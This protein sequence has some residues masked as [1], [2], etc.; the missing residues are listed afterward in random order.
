M[1]FWNT[2]V[3]TWSI[4]WTGFIQGIGAGVILVPVQMVAFSQ[5]HP[6]QRNEGTAVFNLVR[7]MFSSIGVSIT[8]A[9]FVYVG[10]TGRAEMVEHINPYNQALQYSE[11][12]GGYTTGSEHGLAVIGKEIDRQASMLG[13]N[14]SFMML[15]VGS[16]A[17][18]PMVLL[19]GRARKPEG[20]GEELGE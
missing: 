5:L 15:A 17:A 19:I 18:M 9:V 4:V 6:R 3:G 12:S 16:F 1:A 20:E 14:A 11:H 2:N 8:L 7:T 13:Y 10:S